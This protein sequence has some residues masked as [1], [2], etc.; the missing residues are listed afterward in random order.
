M[1]IHLELQA[2]WDRLQSSL[3][4]RPTL[5]SVA[6]AGLAV[7]M[8]ATDQ[9]L[10]LTSFPLLNAGADDARALL[11][12]ITSSMLT[13]TTVT[14][15]IIMVALVLASQQFSPRIIRNF[16][17]DSASQYVL[18]I[19]IGTFIYSL[20]VLGRISDTENRVFVPVVSTLVAILLTLAS[21]STF[22]Y[23][24]H[25]IAEAIQANTI[26]ARA[27]EKTVALL[28]KL[29]PEKIGRP[30]SAIAAAEPELPATPGV[31][32]AA[33][34][35]G[36]IQAIDP[37]ALL[38]LAG[39][40][41]LLIRLEREIG[42]FVPQGNSLLRIWPEREFS[43][44]ET[45]A[46]QDVF[47]I[48]TERTLFDDILFGIRQLVDIALKAISPAVNDPSTA[49]NAIDYLG[50]VLVQAAQRSDPE[51]YRYDDQGR[52]RVIAQGVTFE[53]MVDGAFGPIRQYASGEVAVTLRL[54]KTLHEIAQATADPARA[55]VLW[56]HT[57]MIARGA[58]RG[59]PEPHDR[60]QIN[61][62]IRLLADQLGQL[63]GA[64]LLPVDAAALAL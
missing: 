47:E 3:W 25:H 9:A 19:F 7:A 24:I 58:V 5:L 55:G 53:Q 10:E 31:P 40:Y 64:A 32:I 8:V 57:Q 17:R 22:I 34:Q 1:Q 33:A 42:D 11:S 56:R 6:A 2:R 26:V 51:L 38:R 36:Y 23:F 59:I 37:E 46:L 15:S 4:F 39:E 48:G 28:D 12:S 50:N 27:G 14:F 62:A 16:M 52:L 60:Q 49:L 61:Q 35:A 20:L 18:G 29:F 43:A 63:P 41:D 21:I 44:T 45:Q 54:L 13:V 30:A